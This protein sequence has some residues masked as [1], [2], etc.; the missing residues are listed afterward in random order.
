MHEV[1]KIESS[2][3]ILKIT[4]KPLWFWKKPKILQKS[5]KPRFQNMKMHEN[6]R[7]EAYQVK[8]NLINLEECLRK[9]LD[10]K[11]RVFGK[12]TSADRSREIERDH[13][14]HIYRSSVILDR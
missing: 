11:E 13:E 14:E 12:W 5:Q 10:V 8:K 9:R 1:F 3:P 7:I 4:Q 6:E 2:K